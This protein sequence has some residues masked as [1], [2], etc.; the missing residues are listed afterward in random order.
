LRRRSRIDEQAEK[1]VMRRMKVAGWAGALSLVSLM[2]ATNARANVPPYL[3][4]QGRLFDTA[5]NPITMAVTMEFNLYTQATGGTAVWTEKQTIT[6]ETGYFSAELGSMT[7]F[8]QPSIFVS[9]AANGQDLYLGVT[10]GSDAEILPRQPL[11]SVPY[12]LV[13]DNA[14]GN[15][16]PTTVS[17]GA[18]PVID[19]HGQWVGPS[20]G[21]VGPT[22]PAGANGAQGPA[23]PAGAPGAQ[24]PAGSAGATGLAG[25]A[26]AAGAA[27]PQGPQGPTGPSLPVGVANGL[28]TLN[29]SAQ[30]TATQLPY[31][32]ANGIAE[33]DSTGRTPAAG[34]RNG[35]IAVQTSTVSNVTVTSNPLINLPGLDV[36][37]T[38]KPGDLLIIILENQMV[39][40]VFLQASVND[41]GTAVTLPLQ[42]G[43][44]TDFNAAGVA[45]H[46]V[47][48]GG[49]G[50]TVVQAQC[51]Q[52]GV[53]ATNTINN[54]TLT[55]MQFR[56]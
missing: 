15:I 3:T 21:L 51:F 16:T 1:E 31:N 6:P 29:A 14:V 41:T 56:P 49:S 24:G 38:T 13:A 7:P 23:G 47:G 32:I 12:A 40:A 52:N 4:E 37:L 44:N 5:G 9:A 22:G 10:V 34:V 2:W 11:Q 54:A 45:Y 25:P 26:G 43:A 53:A 36:S 48:T 39:G 50:T 33:A 35:L 42:V 28:A 8:P 20:S 18:T 55:V 17:I 27:G 46:V 19:A 30:V